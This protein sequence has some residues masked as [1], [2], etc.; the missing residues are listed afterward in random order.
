MVPLGR[1]LL[2][3]VAVLAALALSGCKGVAK[4]FEGLADSGTSSDGSDPSAGDS[5]EGP[6]GEP[7]VAEAQEYP[8]GLLADETYFYWTTTRP[9]RGTVYRAR[10]D[11]SDVTAISE[12]V[13]SLEELA[14]DAKHVYFQDGSR[15]M[16]VPK[17]GGETRALFDAK[18][19]GFPTS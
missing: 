11:G 14:I 8:G 19:L 7:V 17:A 9:D 3:S 6:E 4:L 5:A 16:T 15:L 18:T 2:C 10:F 1:A 12:N 13:A